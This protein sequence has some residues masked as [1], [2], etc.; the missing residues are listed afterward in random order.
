MRTSIV[1]DM[2]VQLDAF[3]LEVHEHLDCEVV[4]LF[5]PT[6][7]GKTTMLETIAGLQPLTRRRLA[8]PSL[9]I[10][11]LPVPSRTGM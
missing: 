10:T 2:L 8:V 7:S 5:G 9:T 11:T 6:G 4:A 3:N 1:L